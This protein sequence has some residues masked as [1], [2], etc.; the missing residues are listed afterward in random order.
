MQDISPGRAACGLALL[1]GFAPRLLVGWFLRAAPSAAPV[2]VWLADREAHALVALDAELLPLVRVHAPW[3][4]R[5]I[6][7]S[8]GGVWALCARA[9][10]ARAAH[11]LRRYGAAGELQ[12]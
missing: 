2:A 4:M 8:D 6:A 3:P 11:E 12:E 5:V 7:R 10:D 9:G 1:L